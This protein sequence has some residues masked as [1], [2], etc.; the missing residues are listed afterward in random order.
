MLRLNGEN[1][2]PCLMGLSG[3]TRL[4]Y[5]QRDLGRRALLESYRGIGV[6]LDASGF[7]RFSKR[8]NVDVVVYLEEFDG[9]VV[10]SL[11]VV[12]PHPGEEAGRVTEVI[13]ERLTREIVDD[14]TGKPGCE[15]LI[16]EA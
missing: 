6:N 3:T 12:Q 7:E 9:F 2:M 10:V 13:L 14:T 15:K 11:S 16:R 5:V 4:V 1:E 8:F